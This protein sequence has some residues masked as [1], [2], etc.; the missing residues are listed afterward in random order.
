[1]YLDDV[2]AA[3]QLGIDLAGCV[4]ADN[5]QMGFTESTNKESSPSPSLRSLPSALRSQANERMA[6]LID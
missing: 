1:M 2:D 4:V 3:L 6:G 5:R